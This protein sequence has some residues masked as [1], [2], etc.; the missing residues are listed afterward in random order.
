MEPTEFFKKKNQRW[1]S[2]PIGFYGKLLILLTKIGKQ[3]VKY[4]WKEYDDF[5]CIE[6]EMLMGHQSKSYVQAFRGSY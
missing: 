1:Q 3:R 5:V 6:L 4:G 2:F